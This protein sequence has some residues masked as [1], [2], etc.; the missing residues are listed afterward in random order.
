MRAD[1]SEHLVIAARARAEATRAR[2]LDA[3]LAMTEAGERVTIA[4]VAARGNVSRAWLYNSPELRA[5]IADL[6][7]LHSGPG[8]PVPAAQRGSDASLQQ[9]LQVAHRRI[10]ELTGENEALRR[11]VEHVLGVARAERLGLHRAPASFE[12]LPRLGLRSPGAGRDG[13]E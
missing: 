12:G 9:R 6:R 1:N 11:Q 3:L 4:T 10:S 5:R 2:A 13:S 7:G 8:T